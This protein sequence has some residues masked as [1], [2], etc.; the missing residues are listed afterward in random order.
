[1]DSAMDALIPPE[2]TFWNTI[3]R[4]LVR[5]FSQTAGIGKRQ[6]GP[7]RK[8]SYAGKGDIFQGPLPVI[9]EPVFIEEENR[10]IRETPEGV[11]RILFVDD[12]EILV[13]LAGDVLG[14]MGYELTT[15][16]RSIEALAHVEQHPDYYDLVI[17]DMLMPGMTGD[18][19]S[20]EIFKIN[21]DIPIIL[22]SG[23]NDIMNEK[24]AAKMGIIAFLNKPVMNDCLRR[25]VKQILGRCYS[26]KNV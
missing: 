4:K 23:F 11:K 22:C 13:E 21:P 10:E 19:L 2:N 18:I 8:R 15:F 20:H 25:T 24:E 1:M 5:T 14:P 6:G 26:V 3:Q 17:T 7:N 9:S 16:T 12:E